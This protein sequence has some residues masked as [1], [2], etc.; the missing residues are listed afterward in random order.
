[1]TLET[2]KLMDDT[3]WQLLYEL[4][5]NARQSY[6]ELGDRVGLSSPAVAERIAKMEEAGIISGYHA[7]INL[8][9]L[10]LPVVAIVYLATI[11]G[12]SC[13]RT[14]DALMTLP[15][16]L[17]CYRLTGSDSIILKVTATSLDHLAAV[18]DKIS[19]HGV[20]TTSIVRTVPTEPKI[21]TRT[22]LDAGEAVDKTMA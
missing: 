14:A 21:I 19:V 3:G 16:V 2:G 18:I 9:K 15:E 6:R 5:K 12:Q 4:Q 8:K 11:G 10:G 17:E 20:P 7:Q 22:L 1:M 13:A